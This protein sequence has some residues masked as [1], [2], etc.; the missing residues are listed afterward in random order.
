ME[1]LTKEQKLKAVKKAYN[2]FKKGRTSESK[3]MCL[4]LAY[5]IDKV[6]GDGINTSSMEAIRLIPEVLK[7]KPEHKDVGSAWWE[8]GEKEPRIEAFKSLI[9]D[10]S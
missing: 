2:I 5:G 9:K 3:F 8:L 10:L 4:C 6:V 7:Y 1:H